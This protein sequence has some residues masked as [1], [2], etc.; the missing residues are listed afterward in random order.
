MEERREPTGGKMLKV[1][2]VWKKKKENEGESR[3]LIGK[4]M[5]GK[6]INKRAVLATMRKG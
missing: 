6:S 4:I 3:M 1:N 2:T 5:A